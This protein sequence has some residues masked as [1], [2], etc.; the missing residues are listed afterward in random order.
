MAA[1]RDPNCRVEPLEPAQP[2]RLAPARSQ[3]AFAG[4]PFTFW[5]AETMEDTNIRIIQEHLAA[6]GRGDLERAV[7]CVAERTNWQSPASR[8]VHPE[9]PWAGLR[10]TRADV[11]EFFRLLASAVRP[12]GFEVL[13]MTAQGN[14]VVVEGRNGGRVVASGKQYE[15]EWVMVFTI[16]D[17][18]IVRHRH[19]YD[20]A[21]V[22][23]AFR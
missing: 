8:A 21:G 20:T 5:Y 12:T 17:G 4:C 16:E 23:E 14:R 7:A 11:A 3:H 19:Y 18:K 15:H 22:V 13:A 10:L 1:D 6:F 9:L 2:L